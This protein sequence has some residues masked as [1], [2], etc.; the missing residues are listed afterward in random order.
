MLQIGYVMHRLHARL[1][2]RT[3]D[4]CHAIQ[5]D[6]HEE[7]LGIRHGIKGRHVATP[8]TAQ[9]SIPRREAGPGPDRVKLSRDKFLSETAGFLEE[10]NCPFEDSNQV[11][12]CP[13]WRRSAIKD[14]Q[15]NLATLDDRRLVHGTPECPRAQDVKMIHSCLS[16]GI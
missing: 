10:S 12:L 14:M 5:L 2:G 11:Y 4:A 3:M 1:P 13:L 7:R 15:A 9:R 8:Q 6:G 16:F